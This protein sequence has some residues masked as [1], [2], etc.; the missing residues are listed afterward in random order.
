M[1]VTGPAKSSQIGTKGLMI[2][3]KLFSWNRPGARAAVASLELAGLPSLAPGCAGCGCVP[4]SCGLGTDTSGMLG[5]DT[6]GG[7]ESDVSGRLGTDVSGF[8]GTDT[9]GTG[10]PGGKPPVIRKT[11]PGRPS[12]D[13]TARSRLVRLVYRMGYPTEG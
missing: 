5:T 13:S 12:W 8:E 3:G 2:K 4:L 11:V 10:V 7:L 6:S 1:Y 9:S